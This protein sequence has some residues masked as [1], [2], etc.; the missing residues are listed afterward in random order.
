M[1]AIVLHEYAHAAT[2]SYLGDPTPRYTGRLTLN[3]LAH[4]DPIGMLMLLVFHFGWAKPVQI[5]PSYYRDWRRGTLLVSLAGP[6]MNFSVAFI[7]LLV[8]RLVGPDPW[9]GLGKVLSWAV[10]FNIYLGVFN[11]IPVPPL[12]GSK[13]LRSLL[14]P[15]SAAWYGQLEG[16][17]WLILILL[18]MSGAV[19]RILLPISRGVF[20]LFDA[21]ARLIT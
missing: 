20:V 3:P 19:G 9:G 5:N 6:V 8:I 15:A 10:W 18:L 17:G 7:A 16:F 11:L 4:I 12:D 14:P 1:S 13:V 2:S 21:A